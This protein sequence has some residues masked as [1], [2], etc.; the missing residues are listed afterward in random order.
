MEFLFSYNACI[1][2]KFETLSW[3]MA[4]Y[5]SSISFTAY[6]LLLGTV[7]CY[8]IVWKRVKSMDF[9]KRSEVSRRRYVRTTK[10]VALIFLVFVIC[11]MPDTLHF[12][13]DPR[14][15]HTPVWV[16]RA[17]VILYFFNSAVNP[18][19]FAWKFPAYRKV[20][21]LMLTT[22]GQ[23]RSSVV[24]SYVTERRLTYPQ[25]LT[26]F[27]TNLFSSQTG[28]SSPKEQVSYLSSV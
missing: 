28:S 16:S 24:S 6:T 23:R 22:R 27:P 5:Y 15:E 8:L 14:Y 12:I 2:P 4:I 13:V 18:F 7:V 1:P 11:W 3:G 21:R 20:L 17:G 25:E 19:L 10:N 26:T 9:N